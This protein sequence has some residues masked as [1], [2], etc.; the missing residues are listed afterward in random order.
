MC[1]QQQSSRAPF[2]GQTVQ[3]SEKRDGVR[4]ER[5]RDREKFDNVQTPFTPLVLR[6]ERLRTPQLPCE[7]RMSKVLRRPRLNEGQSESVITLGEDGV[8]HGAM[9]LTLFRVKPKRGYL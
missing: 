6:D 5:T 4:F 9:V 2:A 3:I 1:A 8:C 7:L